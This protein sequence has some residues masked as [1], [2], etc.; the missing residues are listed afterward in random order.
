MVEKIAFKGLNSEQATAISQEEFLKM[1]KS[2]ERRSLKKNFL[3]YKELV[4]KVDKIKKS[5]GEKMIKT[6]VREAVILPQ[7]IGLKFGVHN[8]KEFQ[9]VV[10]LPSMI[11]RR[12]GDFAYTTK[13]V[14]HSSPGIRATKGSKFLGEK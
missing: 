4:Q 13:R 5:G 3:K 12:L 7:W 6:H 1:I 9:T 10:I 8:G 2:R 14:L 11:G